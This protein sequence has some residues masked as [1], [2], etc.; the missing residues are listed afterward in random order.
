MG[1]AKINWTK[2][3][4]ENALPEEKKNKSHR[5]HKKKEH[6]KKIKLVNTLKIYLQNRFG[7]HSRFKHLIKAWEIADKNTRLQFINDLKC[8]EYVLFLKTDYWMAIRNHCIECSQYKCKKCGS[9]TNL[10]VHHKTYVNHGKEH[11]CLSD[12]IVLCDH[13]HYDAHVK[14][15]L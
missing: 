10:Q 2:Y 15:N 7:K 11:L 14:I 5:K 8:K 12:L 3:Q 1:F 4:K 6:K 13:C 9:A